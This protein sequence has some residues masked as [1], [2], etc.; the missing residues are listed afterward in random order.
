MSR[1]AIPPP[2][3]PIG[4]HHITPEQEAAATR[5]VLR[6]AT[7]ED[8]ADQLLYEIGLLPDPHALPRDPHRPSAVARTH[9]KGQP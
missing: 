3:H 6:H 4:L 8:D 5:T 9:R 1:A 7:S 2:A